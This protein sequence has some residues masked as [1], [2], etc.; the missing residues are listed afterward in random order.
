M[1]Y[2]DKVLSEGGSAL[3]AVEAGCRKCED[4]QCDGTVGWGG[5][6]DED[7]E[8]TLD[9]MIMDGNTLNVGAV[10]CLRNIKPAVSVARA[11]LDH[12]RHSLLVGEKATQFAVKMGFTQ[13]NISSDDSLNMWRQWKDNNCQPNFW[14]NMTNSDSQCGPYSVPYQESEHDNS[15]QWGPGHHDTIGIIAMDA[16]GNI[17]AATSTNGARFKIPG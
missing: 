12:T 16:G 8:S 14:N 9:A 4:L 11:V 13:E 2:C 10:G 6:P 17:A 7:G 1:F 15:V 5:S 3:D